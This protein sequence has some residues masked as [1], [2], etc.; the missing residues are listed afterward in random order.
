MWS[1][2]LIHI[3]YMMVNYYKN[4][5]TLRCIACFE[6]WRY[7]YE[8]SNN[9]WTWVNVPFDAILYNESQ[10]TTQRTAHTLLC[11]H[12]RNT[13]QAISFQETSARGYIYHFTRKNQLYLALVF[14]PLTVRLKECLVAL[15]VV[16][17][18]ICVYTHENTIC[19]QLRSCALPASICGG[20]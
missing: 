16:S 3:F 19:M 9:W 4:S 11:L 15:G 6:L 5:F 7:I 2:K 12:W 1:S 13:L 8:L 20:A 17:G 14:S 10:W 18:S